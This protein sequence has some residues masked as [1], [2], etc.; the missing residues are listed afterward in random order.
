MKF[1]LLVLAALMTLMPQVAA[2]DP[3]AELR[4]AYAARDAQAAAAAY[5]PDGEF[6]NN[7][8][9]SPREYY[10]GR[11]AIEANFA[12]LF[13]EID[14]KRKLDINFRVT[15]A[16]R[17]TKRGVYRLRVGAKAYFGKFA[18]QLT[19][20]GKFARDESFDG[21][22]SDF[23]DAAGP[24]M[25][26]P[27]D[28]D[29]DAA[30]Y[31]AMVGRYRVSRQCDVVITRSVIR[32]MARNTCTNEWRGLQR[33][34]G[35]EWAAGDHVLPNNPTVRYRFAVPANGR[36]PQVKIGTSTIAL[37]RD[38][39]RLEDVSFSSR[40]GTQLAGTLYIPFG[41]ADRRAATVLV[42]GSGGQA[43]NGYASIMAVLADQLASQGRVVLIYDKR[44]VGGSQGDWTRAG[45]GVLADDAIAGMTFLANRTEVDPGRVGLAGSSQA[46]WVAAQ[47][48]R[49]G[50]KPA[51]VFLLGAAGTALTVAEQNLYNTEVRMRCARIADKD[52]DLAL[53]QQRAFFAF[54]AD[55][56]R[57][58]ELDR[59]TAEGRKRAGLADWLFPDSKTIDPN[60][61]E[62]YTTLD[63][64][65]DPMP[66]WQSYKGRALFVYSENDDATPTDL[67]ISRLLNVQAEHRVL[68]GAQHLGLLTNDKCR[69]EFSD[70][71]AFAPEL[72]TAIRNF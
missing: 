66:V 29:L 17:S 49:Q 19:P 39:Y 10:R 34:S 48:I 32:L 21:T 8:G 54:L 57:A 47:A 53:A 4:D 13:A 58:D 28:E 22:R 45:F 26:A 60:G 5:A 50:A 62:W 63:P 64:A 24:V 41:K 61:G 14:S 55:P 15:E 42:H 3:F 35:R 2:A 69:A 20:D 31:D 12:K 38:L 36:S 68:P 30:Y 52:V 18:V 7:F 16:N 43:R 6:I 37:R 40:D 67:A 65:F 71:S 59:L 51:D 11:A 70:V 27:D 46:G 23:E 33:M 9:K 25:F 56:E 44:G 1:H 72:W